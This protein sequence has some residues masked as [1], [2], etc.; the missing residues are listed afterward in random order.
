MKFATAYFKQ[1]YICNLVDH[2]KVLG[3]TQ[4]N[5]DAWVCSL[6]S[7]FACLLLLISGN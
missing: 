5:Y 1:G 4:P 7:I 6:L 3:L 2:S